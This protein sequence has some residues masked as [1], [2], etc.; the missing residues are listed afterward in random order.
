MSGILWSLPMLFQVS[1]RAEALPLR[2][3]INGG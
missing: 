1:D 2:G 3:E